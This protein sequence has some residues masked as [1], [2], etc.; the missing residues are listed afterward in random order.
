MAGAPAYTIHRAFC[1]KGSGTEKRE[2]TYEG[3]TGESESRSSAASSSSD[4]EGKWGYDQENPH[5][6][7]VIVIDESSMLDQHLL[8]RLLTCTSPQCRIVFVGDAAQLPSVG[9]G[10]VL[11]DMIAS[12]K[13]PVV[14]L[15]EIFRQKDTS[16][17]VYAAHSIF[18]GEVP[19]YSSNS[20]FTLVQMLSEETIL[21]FIEKLSR[22]LYDKRENF[23]VLS[24]RHAGVVGVTNLNTRLRELLNPQDGNLT[25]IRVG[26]DVIRQDDRIMIFHNDYNLGVFNGDVGKVYRIDKKAKEI[27]IKIFGDPP[28]HVCV[29]FKDAHKLIRLAYCCTVHKVQ[30]LEYDVIVMPLIDSFRHQLQ[31][32]LLYT[33]VTRA[34]KKVF[35]VGTQT[36]LATAVANDREDL[37]NTLFRDRLS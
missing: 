15:T 19:E 35:L 8:Y 5:P 12:K 14:N 31:R 23:Q 4:K 10:N 37:R 16:A 34:K 3:F 29:P 9:P 36:A 18:R 13:F 20:D 1:A 28:L 30:G 26:E 7:E 11:R 24:P 27:E 6:A 32:N 21:E 25:E 17:I 22:K 2:F 33:A